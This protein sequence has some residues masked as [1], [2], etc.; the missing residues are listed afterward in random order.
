MLQNSASRQTSNRPWPQNPMRLKTLQEHS[1]QVN[2][3]RR[4]VLN[5]EQMIKKVDLNEREGQFFLDDNEDWNDKIARPKNKIEK[6]ED[7]LALVHSHVRWP[8]TNP[9]RLEHESTCIP[10]PWRTSSNDA[11]SSVMSMF[12]VNR[13]IINSMSV[14][15]RSLHPPSGYHLQRKWR[16]LGHAGQTPQ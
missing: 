2:D 3:C 15:K 16:Y 14:P 13:V 5:Y 8:E 11:E 1:A 6:Q 4:T 9:L 10:N 7:K 12:N